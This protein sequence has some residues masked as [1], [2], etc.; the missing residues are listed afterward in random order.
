MTL[1][2]NG[3]KRAR[4]LC[5]NFTIRCDTFPFERLPKDDVKYIA[6][7]PVEI[8]PSFPDFHLAP[9]AQISY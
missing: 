4:K 8:L 3:H 5:C 7:G 6:Y 2:Q 1:M 9:R